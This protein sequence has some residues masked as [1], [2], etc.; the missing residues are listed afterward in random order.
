M[1]VILD[2]SAVLAVLL[3]ETGADFVIDVL[4]G[5]EL[6]A[7]NLSE[8]MSRTI[9]NG[10]AA[11]TVETI[12]RSYEIAIVPFSASH[13]RRAAELRPASR[14]LGLSLGD[15]ACLALASERGWP[16]LTGDRRL[17][18]FACDLDIRMIR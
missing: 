3:R 18:S 14:H 6:S 5:A 15:R 17:A 13:A 4:R 8:S 12:V 16:I 11:Q 2:A 1:S 7:V 9:D 10:H